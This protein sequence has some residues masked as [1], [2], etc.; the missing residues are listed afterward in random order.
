MKPGLLEIQLSFV[1]KPT[2]VTLK[3]YNYHFVERSIPKIFR[4]I[5]IN[6][7]KPDTNVFFVLRCYI[8]NTNISIGNYQCKTTVQM[9]WISNQTERLSDM[10]NKITL[11]YQ[12]QS[13]T[14]SLPPKRELKVMELIN[15]INYYSNNPH[16]I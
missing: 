12:K 10:I 2:F 6:S 16:E 11:K 8:T 4:Q 9:D 14:A 3:P 1:N 15:Y 7:I 5:N 13:R